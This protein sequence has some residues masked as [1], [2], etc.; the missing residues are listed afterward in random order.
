MGQSRR[1]TLFYP[2][3]QRSRGAGT[4]QPVKLSV[5]LNEVPRRYPSKTPVEN[6]RRGR[7]DHRDMKEA[8]FLNP[9]AC[10]VCSV[11]RNKL[12]VF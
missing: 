5:M 10:S 2:Y 9:S 12:P 7:R 1:G 11:V 6:Y 4:R 8:R 3:R